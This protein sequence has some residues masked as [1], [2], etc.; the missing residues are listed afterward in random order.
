MELCPRRRTLE[1]ELRLQFR[2]PAEWNQ[3]W[4][5]P[6]RNALDWLRDEL[7]P[8]FEQHGGKL[9]RDPWAAR[10]DYI[11]VMLDRSAESV[12][13]FLKKHANHDL[14]REEQIQ[15]LRLLETQRHAM[16]MYT[17]C[18]W[19]FDE[20]S[21]LETVQVMHYAARAIQLA[22]EATESPDLEQ[23][24]IERL[25]AAKSNL[26]E[27]G[28]GEQIYNKWV[29][30]ARVTMDKVAAHYAISGLFEN[31][32]D[33]TKIYCYNINRKSNEIETEGRSRLAV[34]G[35]SVR[36]NITTEEAA[37]T[38]GLLHLGDHNITCGVRDAMSEEAFQG[39]R[40]KL[41]EAFGHADTAEAIRII[42]AE[43]SNRIYS[44][45]TLFRDEQRHIVDLILKDTLASVAGS[46]RTVYEGQAS[47]LHFLTSLNFP[48]PNALAAAAE[49]ALNSQ[50]QQ[51]IERPD[52]DPAV[53]KGLLREAETN[54]VTLDK[55]TLEYAMR[56]RLESQACVFAKSPEELEP[57]KRLRT[58]LDVAAALPFKVILWQVQNLCFAPLTQS[59]ADRNGNAARED[60]RQELAAIGNQL[61]IKGPVS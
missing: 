54:R 33:Q 21:G 32:G 42:D 44:L 2:R 8:R 47:L 15:A 61:H 51:A 22:A 27:H 39:L 18:G 56:K 60:W 25:R 43:F 41:I 59:L 26:P 7:T 30:P 11:S 34:G 49:I 38:F 6:L 50:L 36:S 46:F 48:T 52:F 10:S 12:E 31:Y 24:F 29:I 13:A 20:L 14:S 1:V 45:Q 55:D 16:L 19:F 37:L 23:P 4:R 5:G 58:M 53:I 57:V 35:A 28:D 17:S 9:L 40:A 3:E